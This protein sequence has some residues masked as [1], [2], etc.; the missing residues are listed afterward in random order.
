MLTIAAIVAS[1]CSSGGS[2]DPR[3]ASQP[4]TGSNQADAAT[5]DAPAETAT[6]RPAPAPPTPSPQASATPRATPAPTPRATPTPLPTPTPGLSGPT[7]N[8]S[9]GSGSTAAPIPRPAW[10]DIEDPDARFDA[11]VA[12]TDP[13]PPDGGRL[14]DC[15]DIRPLESQ[16]QGSLGSRENLDDD[17]SNVILTYRMEHLDT[18]GGV[19][20]DR[21]N[22]GAVVLLFTNDPD[23]HREALLARAPSPDDISGIIPRPPIVDPRPLGERDDLGIDVLRVRFSEVQLLATMNNLSRRIFDLGVSSF[24]LDT[25]RNRIMIDFVDPSPGALAAVRR[26]V[27]TAATCISVFRSPEP[28]EGP[29]DV[30]PDLDSEDPLVTCS[31]LPPVRYSRLLAAP[32]IDDVDHPAVDALR[33]EIDSNAGE[34]FPDG[35][36]LVLALRRTY[37]TFITRGDDPFATASFER[38]GRS[39][40]LAG[41]SSGSGGCRTTVALPPGL[42]EV[43]VRLDPTSLPSPEDTSIDLLVTERACANGRE[44]G[45]ALLD[46]EVVE[47]DDAVLV[48]FAVIPVFGGA[49]CPGNPSTA[50]TIELTRPLGDRVL[51]DGLRVPPI[52]VSDEGY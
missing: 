51:L 31:G 44:M 40:V 1:A 33:A 48:A 4:S 17:A 29:L 46:P 15:A 5:T 18:S 35:D 43:D 50:V 7:P 12:A 2:S 13:L 9:G 27:P 49:S 32:S 21:A 3:L 14:V 19:F 47:T 10:L 52:P 41:F 30:I 37:A 8:G 28:P 22:G 39:W 24:G 38:R 20:I 36:W 6:A 16:V 11:L 42:G 25:L 23:P 26:L 45:D 34:P